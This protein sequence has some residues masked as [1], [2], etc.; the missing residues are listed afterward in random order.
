VSAG[1]ADDPASEDA[2]DPAEPSGLAAALEVVGQRWA[3]LVVAELLGGSR[4]FGDLQRALGAP[5]NILST[6][7]RE[8]QA[9][10][11]VYRE[12]MAHNVLAY[13]LT[14]RGRALRGPIEALAR[15]GAG[16]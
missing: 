7:L 12:P 2:E 15:W 14:S 5:T 13:S 16:G 11:L 10:G 4:R 3:L 8:L 9:A 6:R 1:R